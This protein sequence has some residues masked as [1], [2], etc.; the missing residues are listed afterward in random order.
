[1]RPF[2]SYPHPIPPILAALTRMDHGDAGRA[3]ED[4]VE[5][6]AE[7][8]KTLASWQEI[9]EWR[10]LHVSNLCRVMGVHWERPEH[11]LFR[12]ALA[13]FRATGKLEA[14]RLNACI[15]D[16]SITE[17]RQFLAANLLFALHY[18][19]QGRPVC[20][21]RW[22]YRQTAFFSCLPSERGGGDEQS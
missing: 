14:T 15:R 10:R 1:M 8:Q 22:A 11:D 19:S 16:R 9:P 21:Q 3:L 2:P 12:E 13:L 4:L 17:D 6:L 7:T 5:C 20:Y 18:H